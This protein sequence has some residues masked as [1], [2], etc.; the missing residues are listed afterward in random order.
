MYLKRRHRRWYAYHEIPADVQPALGK[1]RF[2]KSLETEDRNEARRR[3][4]VLEVRW[5]SE[6]QQAR[7]GS[8]DHIERDAL[9]WRKAM[10]E[11]PAARDHLLDI[12]ADKAQEM[13]SHAA[14]RAGIDEDDPRLEEL[15]EYDDAHRLI[16]IATG[17]MVR[18]EE[19]L[20]EYLA[21]IGVTAKT[22]DLKRGTVKRF[23]AEFSYIQ[24]VKRGDV[25]RWLNRMAQDGKAVPTIR[26]AISDLRGYWRYL[27]SIELASDDNSPFEK[28]VVPKASTRGSDDE[29]QAFTAEEVVKLLKAAE[30]KGDQQLADLIRLGMWTGARIEELCT[31]RV[32]NVKPHSFKITDGKTRASRREVPIHSK[33][34]PTIARLMESSQDG[35][36]LSGLPST[37]YGDRSSAIGKR[38]GRLKEAQG[39]GPEHVFHSIRKTVATLLENALVPL[40]VAADIL[41]HKKESMTFGH[42][43]QGSWLKVKREALEKIDYPDMAEEAQAA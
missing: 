19:H 1:V 17:K 7:T 38:F 34:K 26:R 12:I 2:A 33:L 35:Y 28:L 13:V 37:K 4:A 31:I 36:L 23:A 14:K 39:F 30:A 3:A 15:P 24:D 32:E 8:K 41:G 6:I 29:R 11:N 40:N 10:Q 20:S 18:L 5:R 43:S 9:Y 21:T 42:Y 25:Q 27:V 22:K 16:A